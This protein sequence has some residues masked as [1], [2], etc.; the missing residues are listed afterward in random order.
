MSGGAFPDDTRAG[1]QDSSWRLW[2]LILIT[3][4]LFQ[5]QAAHAARLPVRIFTTNDGL[6][7][8]TVNCIMQDS[9]GY[10]WFCTD[11]GLSRFNGYQFKNYGPGDGL[12]TGA[13]TDIVES[14][15][16]RYW[17]VTAR[18]GVFCMDTIPGRPANGATIPA[19][20]RGDRGS[21]NRWVHVPGADKADGHGSSICVDRRGVVWC[22][23]SDGLYRL[24]EAGGR[25]R[26]EPFEAGIV[27]AAD[28]GYQ[29]PE[30]MTLD[31]RGRLWLGARSGLYLL[32][33]GGG[34]DRYW[35]GNGFPW[36]EISCVLEDH[37]GQLWIGSTR[38]LC[39]GVMDEKTGRLSTMRTYSTR[40]GLPSVWVASLF[41]TSDGRIW[42]GTSNGLAVFIEKVPGSGPCF[43][44]FGREHG[45]NDLGIMSLA[46]DDHGNLW[47]GTE[48]GGAT[49]IER[50]GMVSYGPSDGLGGSRIAC[51]LQTHSGDLCAAGRPFFLSR[52]DGTRF[53]AVTP[54]A[55]SRLSY[56][57]WGWHQLIVQDHLGEWWFPS[58]EGLYR[59]PA[60]DRVDDLAHCDPIA[61][62]TIRD[63]L[64]G[65]DVFRLFE[66]S[67][68]DLWVSCISKLE[69]LTRWERSTGTFHRY[70][71]ADGIPLSA[72]TAFCED[73]SGKLWIGFYHGGVARY[74]HGTFT[75]F[76]PSADGIPDGLVWC[77]FL[78]HA[79]RL[80]VGGNRGGLGRIDDPSASR[81][82]A[83]HYTVNQGLA[84][85]A[86]RAI[87]EDRWGRIY[88]GT[89]RGLDS[90]DP[91]TGSIRHYTT[92]DGLANNAINTLL[93]DR[94][95]R[96][97]AGTHQGLSVLEPLPPSAES[98]PE[99]L[100]TGVR[101][102]GI[103]Y[104]ISE[105]GESSVAGIRTESSD[106][107]IEFVGFCH[108]AGVALRY[109]YRLDGADGAWSAPTDVRTVNYARLAP[110]DY[111]FEVKVLTST[112]ISSV[113]PG[114]ISFVIL[115]P[116][117]RRWW[118]LGAAGLVVAAGVY[119]VYRFRIERLREMF[120]MRNR[121]ATDLHDEVGS[122]L[123]RIAV[124][125]EVVRRS[126]DGA[127]PESM[128]MLSS[129]ADDARR[130]VDSISDVVWA[131]DPRMDDLDG[132]IAR[133]R[134]FVSDVLDAKSIQWEFVASPDLHHS[135]I[136][137]DH[138]H[139][140]LLIYKE[141][142]NNI[143]RHTSCSA[144]R[145][146]LSEVDGH[147]EGEICD[148]GQGFDTG[149]VK[150]RGG[151]RGLASMRARAERLSGSL[152]I[153]SEQGQGTRVAF[154]LPLTSHRR[155]PMGIRA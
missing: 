134:S 34:S 153:R 92:A 47:A 114:T 1:G 23:R 142:I 82:S 102:G 79:G 44:S 81:P 6:A 97:W 129:I 15:D 65:D 24:S 27:P 98:P 3:V 119:G 139:Q 143:I 75:F 117:W 76:S 131:V 93:C 86:A 67:R 108:T 104:A 147:L 22:G 31:S 136:D 12:S 10:L 154:S 5:G 138:R 53:H 41:E 96:I 151:G 8:D 61:V 50:Q 46:E 36:N 69:L 94:D 37:K 43:R 84:S 7:Q 103:P 32:K 51:I 140:V 148:N 130:L 30:C 17:V 73:R 55:L 78:D 155:P 20:D 116:M 14:S 80:W 137:S 4:A 109:Q 26:F 107:Q 106:V 127:H 71:T 42:A 54:D 59:F 132:L 58:G 123:T 144:V 115:P 101:I 110:G 49:R 18:D 88:V 111:R 124:L 35:T 141:A 128:G 33:P 45:L 13:V 68:G 62:Y 63:G 21:A 29:G 145:L 149:H 87:T 125:S 90:L 135:K 60:V 72:P 146:A 85:N 40:D 112:G 39:S 16:G 150:P 126:L 74:H 56:L 91:T 64:G 105:V 99:A 152:T 66:D 38:G 57:G 100:I 122:S 95:G 120:R 89:V 52:Y 77:L 19:G 28:T 118:F 133:I 48:S 121:I 70:G 11:E 9:H 2:I 25:K 83:V 113:K